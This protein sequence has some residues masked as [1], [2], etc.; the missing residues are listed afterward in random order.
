MV[1]VKRVGDII[2]SLRMI[3]RK[4]TINIISAYVP[5]VGVEAH[6]KEKLWEDMKELIQS[7][8]LTEKVFIG[9]DLNG[10]VGKEVG[11]HARAHGG[12][13]FGMLNNKGQSIID[14]P[15]HIISR[16]PTLALRSGRSI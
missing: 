2:I 4:D 7:I 9:R 1:E 16:L 14:S 11:S 10:H 13:G 3:V 8:P 12:F 15:L 5:Q 6:I